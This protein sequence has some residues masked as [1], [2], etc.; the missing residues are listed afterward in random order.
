[1]ENTEHLPCARHTVKL[2]NDWG[3]TETIVTDTFFGAQQA[4]TAL[5][6][7]YKERICDAWGKMDYFV[8]MRW[9]I[10]Q[11]LGKYHMAHANVVIES[12][13][14]YEQDKREL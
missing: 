7:N 3:R 10:S 5:T 12:W 1:M 11:S 9:R 2:V 6:S 13:I 8:T 4:L 14:K